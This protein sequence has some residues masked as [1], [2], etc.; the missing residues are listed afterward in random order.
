MSYYTTHHKVTSIINFL[1]FWFERCH[2]SPLFNPYSLCHHPPYSNSLL[3]T[4][5]HLLRVHLGLCALLPTELHSATLLVHLTYHTLLMHSL[6][7]ISLL[8]YYCLVHVPLY[9]LLIPSFV[10]LSVL[11]NRP[12]FSVQSIFVVETVC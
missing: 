8:R 2:W 11:A 12:Y 5:N 6:Y 7:H 1:Y 10:M 4:W 3:C 9:F